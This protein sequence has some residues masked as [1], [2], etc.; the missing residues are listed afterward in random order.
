M[1]L[2]LLIACWAASKSSF[3][4]EGMLCKKLL[5]Q[6][7]E[8]LEL[9]QKSCLACGL[10]HA[11]MTGVVQPHKTFRPGKGGRVPLDMVVQD[12][13]LRHGRL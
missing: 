10:G 4:N 11:N 1:G 6:R 13:L 3:G 8:P 7:P 9:L 5:F 12:G 2:L